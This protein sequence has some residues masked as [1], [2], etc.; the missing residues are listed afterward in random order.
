MDLP[1]T[2]N[3]VEGWHIAFQG[4]LSCSHLTIWLLIEALRSEESLQRTKYFG[5]ISEEQ[6]HR[7]RN[8]DD[9]ERRIKNIND[10][11]EDLDITVYLRHLAYNISF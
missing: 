11:R 1:R 7:K 4:S 3:S 9:M 2:N 6:R 5:I 10:S 8:Y